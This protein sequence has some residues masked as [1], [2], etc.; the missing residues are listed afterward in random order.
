MA[1]S[2]PLA[3][4]DRPASRWP[5]ILF[6]VTIAAILAMTWQQA[7]GGNGEPIARTVAF[8]V[9]MVFPL[10]M[11]WWG[12]KSGMSGPALGGIAMAVLFWMALLIA[13]RE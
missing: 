13:G 12:K 7:V 6:F 3:T 4:T 1:S 2:P 11:A 9:P 8:L 5:T 10:G